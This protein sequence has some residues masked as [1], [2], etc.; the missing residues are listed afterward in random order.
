MGIGFLSDL[1]ETS[2]PATSMPAPDKILFEFG[3]E[4]AIS[5]AEGTLHTLVTGSTGSG[6]TTS[7]ILPAV[8]NL[9]RQGFS[10]LIIDIKGNLT[11]KIRALAACC[12]RE[13]DIL[14][15]GIGPQAQP[16]NILTG[17][18]ETRL[19]EFFKTITVKGVQTD[20]NIG[21]YLKGVRQVTDITLLCRYLAKREARFTPTLGLLDELLSDFPICSDLLKSFEKMASSVE[22]KNLLNR[23]RSDH[24]SPCKWA[25]FHPDNSTG[26]KPGAND[27]DQQS[28]WRTRYIRN[29]LSLIREASGVERGFCSAH[30]DGLDMGKWVYDQGRIVILR[31]GSQSGCVGE[32]LSRIC[33]E[34]FYRAVFDRG[35][36]LPA[37]KYTF[38]VADEFQD[39]VD[40][41]RSKLY[42][43]N[44]FTAKSRE[45][46]NIMVVG[47]QSLSALRARGGE[48]ENVE[49][50][51]NNCNNRVFLYSDD[52]WTQ[53]VVNRH[54][55]IH[56]AELGPGEAVMVKF[57]GT[58]RRHDHGWESLQS[59]HDAC[60]ARLAEGETLRRDSEERDT[61]E[62]PCPEASGRL[63]IH[64]IKKALKD[65]KKFPKLFAPPEFLNSTPSSTEKREEG[66]EARKP[67]GGQDRAG[68]NVSPVEGAKI[69]ADNLGNLLNSAGPPEVMGLPGR[70]EVLECFKESSETL[71]VIRD[72]L[73]LNVKKLD[74]LR[75]DNA[76]KVL[77][78]FRKSYEEIEGYFR[79]QY[80]VLLEKRCQF[81]DPLSWPERQEWGSLAIAAANQSNMAEL[82]R[83]SKIIPIE[84]KVAL[85][86]D[87]A[88]GKKCILSL[89][90][91]LSVADS[92]LEPGWLE[93][94]DGL[95]QKAQ[96]GDDEGAEEDIDYDDEDDEDEEKTGGP[97]QGPNSLPLGRPRFGLR[98]DA[99]NMMPWKKMEI[100]KLAFT[101]GKTLNLELP[102]QRT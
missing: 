90:F 84:S 17:L 88:Y 66:G 63:G 53:E 97:R 71:S 37:G 33:L 75:E 61:R 41:N 72:Q 100:L 73:Q 52:P 23:I 59:A 67:L 77:R 8:D 94:Y 79:S 69:N 14:E 82:E 54:E 7:F 95:A 101:L 2:S 5:F 25:H 26:T 34:A 35:L 76:G 22:E 50:F 91:N 80:F 65:M 9:L 11:D 62:L 57:N 12:N 19:Y 24:F 21:W 86:I 81:G 96:A 87:E 78:W 49:C 99:E 28:E 42:N 68:H 44:D 89:G 16:I 20:H 15:L 40:F 56:L 18:T 1:G 36:G 30:S 51:V 43:D 32:D 39:F 60:Q 46:N 47:T 64:L 85:C 55:H 6:K 4:H 48:R 3:G 29:A 45:F 93:K 98:E 70:S 92:E 74:T 13:K 58:T 102:F 83:L 38:L 27:F 10:G 31:F